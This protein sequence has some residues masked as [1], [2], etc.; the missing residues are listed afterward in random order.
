VLESGK[1]EDEEGDCRIT[2][3]FILWEDVVRSEVQPL[4]PTELEERAMYCPL[5]K[6]KPKKMEEILLIIDTDLPVDRPK[7]V[8]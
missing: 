7:K 4:E 1:L 2:L 6:W 3:I 5:G 8:A